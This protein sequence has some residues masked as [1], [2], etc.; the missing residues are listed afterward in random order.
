MEQGLER[1]LLLS[2]TDR[3]FTQKASKSA[4]SDFAALGRQPKVLQERT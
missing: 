4:F 3:K 2:S 1:G